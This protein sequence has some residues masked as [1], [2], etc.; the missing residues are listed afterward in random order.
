[1]PHW[2][3]S[4]EHKLIHQNSFPFI[5]LGNH[6]LFTYTNLRFC[7]ASGMPS[8]FVI[9]KCNK[10][11]PIHA[12]Q[13]TR[14]STYNVYG[15]LKTVATVTSFNSFSHLYYIRTASEYEILRCSST[16]PTGLDKNVHQ[17]LTAHRQHCQPNLPLT[18][19]S[20]LQNHN[21]IMCS[22][23]SRFRTYPVP[24]EYRPLT[25]DTH[26]I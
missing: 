8:D 25:T 24:T 21:K 12:K 2:K 26:R 15:T 16:V 10:Y 22:F 18:S 9:K 13:C 1:M 5:D 6:V 19:L 11:L 14:I 20:T 4:R 3:M 23:H 17:L 7:P